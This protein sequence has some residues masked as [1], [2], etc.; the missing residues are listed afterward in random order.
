MDCGVLLLSV[1]SYQT[2]P[3]HNLL[4]DLPL[5]GLVALDLTALLDVW[6]VGN[7]PGEASLDLSLVPPTNIL[8]ETYLELGVGG[9]LASPGLVALV[10]EEEEEQLKYHRSTSG[11]SQEST[12]CD[13]GFHCLAA[14]CSLSDLYFIIW[15]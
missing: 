1:F 4:A 2:D 10:I 7:L 5:P 12:Y 9:D 15:Y 13:F 3:L 14:L 11:R 8:G 6:Q